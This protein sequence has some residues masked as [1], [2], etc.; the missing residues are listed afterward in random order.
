MMYYNY[1]KNNMHLENEKRVRSTNAYISRGNVSIFIDDT[2]ETAD[3]ENAYI[4]RSYNSIVAVSNGETV[5]L[6]PRAKYSATTARH[7]SEFIRNYSTHGWDDAP[8][9]TALL[10]PDYSGNIKEYKF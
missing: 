6:L 8:R 9:A 4:L 1:A 5:A 2:E 7:V 3:I 10:I